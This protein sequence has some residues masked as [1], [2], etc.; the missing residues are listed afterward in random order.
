MSKSMKRLLAAVLV[1]SMLLGS[2]GVSFAA[3][4]A[5]AENT[6]STEEAVQEIAAEEQEE[7]L[8]VPDDVGTD[9][10]SSV[11]ETAEE[12]VQLPG[13]SLMQDQ[14]KKHL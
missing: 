4:T 5:A 10:E 6:S 2:N 7:D 3:E 12:Q 9:S 14:E 13:R 1:T 8:A 11:E